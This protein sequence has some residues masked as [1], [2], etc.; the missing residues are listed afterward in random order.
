M[1]KHR[2][3]VSAVLLVLALGT[4]ASQF[5]QDASTG[6]EK[7]SLERRASMLGL[8]R[9]IGTAEVGE[10]DKYGSYASWQTL[11]AHEPK[12]L[13]A[14]LAR[15]YYAKEANVHFADM[16]EMLPG[17]NRRLNVHTDGQGDDLLLED[18][19]DKNGYAALLDER[20]VIRE[21]E[22]LQ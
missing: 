19:T 14:W 12:Y 21:C 9:T 11:L 17:W 6:P 2:I 5:A 7:R 10:L 16:P 1:K 13:N 3:I 8:V 4:L 15:F 22:R 20:A 18:A